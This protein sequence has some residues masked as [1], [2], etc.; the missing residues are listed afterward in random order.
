MADELISV[1]RDCPPVTLPVLQAVDTHVHT[2]HS[3]SSCLHV[4]LPLKFVFGAQKSM[5]HL[6]MTVSL[7]TVYYSVKLQPEILPHYT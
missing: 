4:E 7:C 3:V 5:L 6:I 1:S 2:T